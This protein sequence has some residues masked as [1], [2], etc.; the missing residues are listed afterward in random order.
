LDRTQREFPRR[1]DQVYWY[2]R[3]FGAPGT[4]DRRNELLDA[5]RAYFAAY[6]TENFVSR[7]AVL[8]DG[9]TI[10]QGSANLIALPT[11]ADVDK[12]LSEEPFFING[13]YDHV[14]VERYKFGGR[15]GQ[16]V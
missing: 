9:G 1:E 5:H 16:I 11:R 6:D 14:L 10:W 4:N 3:G 12:F 15:P 2:I 7:G 8:D 13:L